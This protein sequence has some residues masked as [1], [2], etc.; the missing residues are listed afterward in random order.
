MKINIILFTVLILFVNNRM[1]ASRKIDTLDHK[2]SSYSILIRDTPDGLYTM[3]QSNLNYLSIYRFLNNDLYKSVKPK[4]GFLIQDI[5]ELILMP[6]THEEGH[7][8]ILTSLGI[9]AISQPFFNKQGVAYVNGVT[10]AQLKN[11]R[12]RNLPDYVRLHTAGIESDY[13]LG[14][15]EE[16]EILF[17][18]DTRQNLMV[19]LFFRKLCTMFYYS[20]SLVPSLEPNLKEDC[21]E[22]KNDVVGH[23]VYGAIKNL[24]R[25]NIDFYRY[26]S[27]EDLL[28]EERR[29]V[30]RTG[31]RALLNIG[32]PVFIKALNLVD[33]DILELSVGTGYTMCPFGD[34]IDENFW[35][36][37]NQ[38]YH[39]L[40]YLRQFENRNTWFLGGGANL[41][42]Y[43]LSSKLITSASFHLWSQPKN[44]DFNTNI[45]RFGGAADLMLKYPCFKNNAGHSLSIDL[46]LCYKT[47]G[48]LPEEVV[49]KEHFGVR[50]GLTV[51]LIQNK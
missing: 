16:S 3:R 14:L 20:S 41:L 43:P 46:G 12:D 28:T 36:Q 13:M 45:G 51:Y 21:N 22:L 4:N 49:L 27:Y 35:I 48:F 24:Y 32:S 9:G 11:L 15:R 8:S 37:Y 40:A 31:Y 5:V 30:K 6:L 19:E 39:I 42:D 2:Y 18:T 25:P 33:N 34:F 7:R 17:N 10:D 29:F 23:D 38:K 47:Y 1:F 50:L 26:T 44:L